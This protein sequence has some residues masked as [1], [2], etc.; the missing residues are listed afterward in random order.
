MSILVSASRFILFSKHR[1]LIKVI[2][3]DSP[4]CISLEITFDDIYLIGSEPYIDDI[5]VICAT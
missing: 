2:K 4:A 3:Y 1:I 5:A